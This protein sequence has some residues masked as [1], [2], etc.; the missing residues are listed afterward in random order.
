MDP[1]E[2]KSIQDVIEPGQH[3]NG[4][5]RFAIYQVKDEVV[6][7]RLSEEHGQLLSCLHPKVQMQALEGLRT[8]DDTPTPGQLRGMIE[9]LAVVL[10]T[11]GFDKSDC[12]SC[13]FN[14]SNHKLLFSQ[15]VAPGLCV[16]KVCAVERSK[17]RPKKNVPKT[18]AKAPGS[19]LD[20]Y[21]EQ[22]WR[23]ALTGHLLH[24][25]EERRPLVALALASCSK[26]PEQSFKGLIDVHEG[27]PLSAVVDAALGAEPVAPVEAF[28]RVI[29]NTVERLDVNDLRGLLGAFSVDLGQ[30]W[31]LTEVLL[32]KLSPEQHVQLWLETGLQWNGELQRA[33]DQGQHIVPMM[34]ILSEY[35]LKGFI[36]SFLGY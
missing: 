18:T 26:G 25:P 5:E 22:L 35:D 24:L 7:G 21:R 16:N 8:L 32:Q 31:V 29:I 10:D 2:S 4:Y 3:I 14:S 23:H 9:Q 6:G 27:Q 1:Y 36:P 12:S 15:S 13:R 30:H 17:S 34:K 19:D 11:Q 20:I 33:L 28:R